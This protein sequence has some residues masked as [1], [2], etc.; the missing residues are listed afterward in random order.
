MDERA[1]ERIAAIRAE[2]QLAAW[3]PQLLDIAEAA[4]HLEANDCAAILPNPAPEDCISAGVNEGSRC[5]VCTVRTRLDGLFM[6]WE[7]SDGGQ[8]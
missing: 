1:L 8:S 4:A 2:R 7:V 5:R 6:S 3:V